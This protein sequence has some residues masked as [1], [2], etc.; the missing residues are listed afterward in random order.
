MI[1]YFQ[2]GQSTAAVKS[3][4]SLPIPFIAQ[5]RHDVRMRDVKQVDSSWLALVLCGFF[6]LSLTGCATSSVPQKKS[7]RTSSSTTGESGNVHHVHNL[8]SG[9]AT[10]TKPSVQSR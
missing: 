4:T 7:V 1:S 9:K 8:K 3:I 2:Y 6:A 10:P 5:I